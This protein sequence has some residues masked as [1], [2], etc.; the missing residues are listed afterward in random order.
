MRIFLNLDTLFNLPAESVWMQHGQEQSC[1]RLYKDGFEGVQ[2]TANDIA[3]AGNGMPHCGLDRIN[4]PEE[5]DSIVAAH[6]QSGDLCVTVHAGW[7]L[8]D[9]SESCRLVDAILTASARY[10]LPIFIETH[11]A[12]VTQ[13]LWRTVQLIRHFPE[14]RLNGDFSHY[15]CGQEMVYGDWSQ[16]IS[17]MEPIFERTGFL[18]GRIASPGCMQVPVDVDLALRPRQAH[19]AANYLEHFREL[20]TRA[21]AGFLRNAQSGDVLIF[22]PELLSGLNY[23]ARM[24]PD[25]ASSLVEESDRY[26]EALLL[27]E[28]ASQCF[29]A[30]Q[31]EAA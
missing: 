16:K 14:M 18:H 21:M 23:Y 5:A 15:Y 31:A 11:R 17:Y 8:E 2:I 29:S 7:G 19:G 24:F 26:A 30:A 12:T 28:L 20:W 25:S 3:L 9:E 27:K 6:E 22:A 1:E 13:D 4:T 10:S